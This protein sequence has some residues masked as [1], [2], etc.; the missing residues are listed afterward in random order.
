MPSHI[1]RVRR[2]LAPALPFL[3]IGSGAQASSF[4]PFNTPLKSD[5]IIFL[6]QPALDSVESNQLLSEN[7]DV[8]LKFRPLLNA[9]NIHY[10]RQT[11]IDGSWQSQPWQCESSTTINQANGILTT[12]DISG[13]LH[14]F[15]LATC[16][17]S[18]S[19]ESADQVDRSN[20]CSTPI[21]SDPVL[22][23]NH[24]QSPTI[25]SQNH[26]LHVTWP[27]VEGADHYQLEVYKNGQWYDLAQLNPAL[28]E[29]TPAIYKAQFDQHGYFNLGDLGNGYFDFKV[30][31]CYQDNC[32]GSLSTNQKLAVAPQAMTFVA[33]GSPLNYTDNGEFKAISL[34]S[35]PGRFILD[36]YPPKDEVSYYRIVRERM[37]L[38]N[39][40]TYNRTRAKNLCIE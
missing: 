31:T 20:I 30:K 38:S 7:G 12:S 27:Q 18:R 22:V 14:R 36:V 16:M 24:S 17:K 21:F 39:G 10:R 4:T 9:E 3:L 2:L 28:T 40:T 13:G 35:H 29:V 5:I 26:E 33:N 1:N 19:C 34:S 32:S 37:D 25:S 6:P 11:L 8:D 15:E 23:T